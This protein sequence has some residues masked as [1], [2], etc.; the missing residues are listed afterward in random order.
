MA[1]SE[2]YRKR[3]IEY[4][5]EGH[6]EK[7]LYEA[8]KV[9]P[10]TVYRWRKLLEKTG[11]LSPEYKTTRKRKIDKQELARAVERKP[12]ITLPELAKMFNCTKQSIDVALKKIK[13]TRKKRH[14][15]TP[16]STQQM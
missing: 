1:Y 5:N 6:S 15:R 10:S 2:D 4:L 16:K 14:S 8:F 12:D 13:I 7:E 11:S 9:N 3:A